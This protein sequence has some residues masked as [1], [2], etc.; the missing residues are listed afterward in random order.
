M[1]ERTIAEINE[2]V[3]IRMGWHKTCDGIWAHQNHGLRFP[4]FCHDAALADEFRE[5]VG[6]Q[7][8]FGGIV[9][10]KDHERGVWDIYIKGCSGA[11]AYPG[12]E[13]AVTYN[14]ASTRACLLACEA[15]EGEAK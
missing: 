15:Q 12:H 3:A 1:A 7:E 11:N 6:S 14:E 8:W 13:Q 9:A 5:F 10:N 4:E 2:A